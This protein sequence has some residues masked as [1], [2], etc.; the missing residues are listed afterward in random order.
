MLRR[1][2]L[3]KEEQKTTFFRICVPTGSPAFIAQVQELLQ[4]VSPYTVELFQAEAAIL[5]QNSADAS[6]RLRTLAQ[7]FAEDVTSQG[8]PSSVTLPKL[9]LVSFLVERLL[10]A[11]S[12]EATERVLGFFSDAGFDHKS[13]KFWTDIFGSLQ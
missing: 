12:D 4:A 2:T 3:N 13:P 1:V 9:E 5:S 11:E 6:T 8:R 10:E 7:K